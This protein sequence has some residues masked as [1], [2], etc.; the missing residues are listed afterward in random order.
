[1][2][3]FENIREDIIELI[4]KGPNKVLEIGCGKG[5]TLKKLLELGKA[6][7]IAGIE[8][9]T[10]AADEARNHLDYV[11]CEDIEQMSSLPFEKNFFDFIIFAD[12][13]EHLV[14]PWK[15][16][17]LVREYL[18]DK[19]SVIA[20]VP[21]LRHKSVIAPLVFKGRFNYDPEGGLLDI[22]HLRFYTKESIISLFKISGYPKIE[23]YDYPLSIKAKIASFLT[24]NFLKDFFVYKFRII[25]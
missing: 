17:D 6:N 24:F 9:D 19:G 10:K 11:V 12:V 21:N 8:I 18:N 16:L 4:P 14:N 23:F 20:T 15:V 13:L 25:A 22:S 2:G 5:Y 1:M 7:Y 3:Y